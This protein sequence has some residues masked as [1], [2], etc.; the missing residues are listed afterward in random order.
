MRPILQPHVAPYHGIPTVMNEALIV[1][2]ALA[3]S[4]LTLI[5]GFGLGTLLLPVFAIF[6]PLELA[7]SMT[8]V[9][10]LLNELF[11]GTLLWR[12]ID[13]RVVLRFG[14]PGIL[15]AWLGASSFIYFE[16]LPY[17]YPGVNNPVSATQV[18]IGLLMALFAVIELLPATAK[19]AVPPRFL[20]P[21]G[22]LSGFL[23]GLSGHQGALRSIFLLR[24]G[25]SKDAFIATGVAIACLVDVT[26]IPIYLR[27]MPLGLLSERGPLLLAT[28]LAAFFG[29]WLGK[30]LIPKITLR[31]VQLV[32]GGLMLA[33]AAALLA[34][35]L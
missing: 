25:M 17:L 30:R 1:S 14:V 13:W 23:G 3:A 32:V 5:S 24:Y 4:L 33:I 15:G 8:A 7:L 29:A 31:G 2:A 35:V 34:G 9:V 6:F 22:L 20:V 18:V 12:S 26:R 11:K 19:W 27:E 16:G 21:G 10:H 28:T